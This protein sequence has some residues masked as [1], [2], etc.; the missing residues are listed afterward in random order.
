MLHRVDIAFILTSVESLRPERRERE[1]IFR[2]G[3]GGW[4]GGGGEGERGDCGIP[5]YPAINLLIYQEIN[6]N[7]CDMP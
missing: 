2:V 7:S 3:Q 1:Q 6:Q 5:N 4:G